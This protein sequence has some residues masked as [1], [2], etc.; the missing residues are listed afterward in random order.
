[1]LDPVYVDARRVLLDV[2]ELLH[3]QREAM[4]LIGA[5]AIY[6]HIG[7]G[8]LAIL[9]YTTDADFALE[10]HRLVDDPRL[11]EALE[12]AS[13]MP[14]AQQGAIGTWV[15]RG[16]HGNVP[17]DFLVPVALEPTGGRAARLGIHGDRTA[18]RAKGLAGVMVDRDRKSIGA[19]DPTDTRVH[20]LWVAGPGAL[21]VAKLHKIAERIDRSSR[22]ADKDALDVY[23]LLRA[24]PADAMAARLAQLQSEVG[25]AAETEATEALD[26]L[27]ALFSDPGAAGCQM[28][29]RAVDPL[30]DPETTAL[31]CS[32]L[33][34]ELLEELS[35]QK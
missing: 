10:P 23:R 17:V 2:L 1:M 7:A 4:V 13:F 16:A 6:L 27:R 26:F 34:K 33:A 3:E 18:R 31:A 22:R 14:S 8:D 11:A 15:T 28:V 12:R 21:L 9:P 30:E 5:Q 35:E 20:D 32:L 24:F 19:L 25:S 29:G